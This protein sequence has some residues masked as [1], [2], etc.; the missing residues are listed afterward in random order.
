MMEPTFSHPQPLPE[1]CLWSADGISVQTGAVLPLSAV[2]P[3]DLPSERRTAGFTVMALS[4][5]VIASVVFFFLNCVIIL[6]MTQLIRRSGI[7]FV[8]QACYIRQ[9][10]LV[11]FKQN[12]NPLWMFNLILVSKHKDPPGT[13]AGQMWK[14]C[15]L[16]SDKLL[17][18]F[19]FSVSKN[20]TT[21]SRHHNLFSYDICHFPLVSGQTWT[22]EAGVVFFGWKSLQLLSQSGRQ[23]S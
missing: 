6:L 16:P 13:S 18:T 22:L 15:L 7:R 3:G 9:E 20:T 8:Y 2:N 19:L 14:F 11:I 17:K 12:K 4:S 21:Y 1:S 5:D 10:S 23:G